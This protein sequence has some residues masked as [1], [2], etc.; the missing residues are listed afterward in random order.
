MPE[1][2][3]RQILLS[4]TTH[5][6]LL[7]W[8]SAVARVCRAWWL[9]AQTS[10]AYG[11]GLGERASLLKDISGVLQRAITGVR[12]ACDG[13]YCHEYGCTYEHQGGMRVVAGELD[14]DGSSAMELEGWGR[15]L[16]AAMQAMPRP[17]PLTRIHLSAG[18]RS[19]GQRV[20][21]TVAGMAP[22]TAVLKEGFARGGLTSLA[23]TGHHLLGDSGV[24]ALAKAL[25]TTLRHLWLEVV[26]ADQGMLA[27][28]EALPTMTG[29][30]VLN[31]SENH[32]VS[33]RGWS[34]LAAVLPLLRELRHLQASECKG[35]G[36]CVCDNVGRRDVPDP[37][38][39]S[40]TC[41]CEATGAT[42]APAAFALAAALPRCAP[43]LSSLHLSC[44]G[45]DEQAVDT[46]AAAWIST[47]RPP[48][49]TSED[50]HHEDE[51]LHLEFNPC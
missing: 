10:A 7:R 51:G 23:L 6:D 34:A 31:F 9:V 36:Q 39:G 15:V 41:V 45:L 35:W 8:I 14:H 4:S 19:D 26:Y 16:G 32:F 3:L 27:I 2:V 28:A 38:P 13:A 46:L 47:G 33:G 50:M 12:C 1:H 49:S 44:C 17:V 29:M 24:V 5:D 40:V 25:P 22:I 18:W 30:R 48:V 20:G 11:T 42:R 43:S 37:L 21:L